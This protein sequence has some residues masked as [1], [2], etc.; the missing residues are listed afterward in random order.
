MTPQELRSRRLALEITAGE[1]AL[2]AH[3]PM[4]EVYAMERGEREI[5]DP[6]PFLSVFDRLES[7]ANVPSSS[8]TGNA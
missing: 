7:A 3:V 5:A 8:R 2:F 1:L 6:E 4:R